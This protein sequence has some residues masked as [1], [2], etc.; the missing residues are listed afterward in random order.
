MKIS[1]WCGH[2][3]RIYDC[4]FSHKID[5]VRQGK[6]ILN[7]NGHKNYIFGSK[8]KGIFL[9]QWILPIEGFILGRVCVCSLRSRLASIYKYLVSC[10]CVCFKLARITFLGS[11]KVK[12]F[13]MMS[14]YSFSPSWMGS[15]LLN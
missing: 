13:L 1:L 3:Q 15:S 14:P 2:A 11:H 10:A 12:H 7:L 5:Y 4:A 8:E 6:N 9:K